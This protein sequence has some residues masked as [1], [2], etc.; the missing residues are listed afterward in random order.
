MW[1]Y[2]LIDENLIICSR[3]FHKETNPNSVGKCRFNWGQSVRKISA[4]VLKLLEDEEFL[5]HE[6]IKARTLTRGIQGFGNFSSRSFPPTVDSRSGRFSCR[7]FNSECTDRK[8]DVSPAPASEK[9]VEMREDLKRKLK[10]EAN[11]ESRSSE[12]G[13]NREIDHP[14]CEI[15]HRQDSQSLISSLER[16]VLSGRRKLYF[17]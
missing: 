16:R 7:Q 15:K 13:E 5:R 6:R 8:N 10:E 4:R 3:N 17:V 14:F 9:D 11:S 1:K 2:R 12:D